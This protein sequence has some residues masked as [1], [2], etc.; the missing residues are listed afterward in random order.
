M[1][2]RKERGRWEKEWGKGRLKFCLVIQLIV[3]KFKPGQT[4]SSECTFIS[5]CEQAKAVSDVCLAFVT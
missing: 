3:T 4:E 2:E 1:R 5:E